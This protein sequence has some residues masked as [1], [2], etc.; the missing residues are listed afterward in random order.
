MTLFSS[1]NNIWIIDYRAT[2]HMTNFFLITSLGSSLVKSFQVTNVIFMLI[3]EARN[4][5]LL[6]IIF[7]SLVL[8]AH[9]LSNNLQ[10][11]KRFNCSIIF[12]SIYCVFYDNLMKMIVDTG[13]EK[14]FVLL[15]GSE[16]IEI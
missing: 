1:T 9:N 4:V 13:R 14:R 6:L 11:I 15:E 2:S 3:I 8:F 10:I 7:L 16:S 5:S 12:Y